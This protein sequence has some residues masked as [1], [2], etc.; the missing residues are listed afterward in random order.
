MCVHMYTQ[1]RTHVHELE[2]QIIQSF[3]AHLQEEGFI[4]LRANSEVLLPSGNPLVDVD[5][6]RDVSTIPKTH[7][8]H[9]NLTALL[10]LVG[11]S[12]QWY[13]ASERETLGYRWT[14]KTEYIR[15]FICA[16]ELCNI[17]GLFYPRGLC[18]KVI[19]QMQGVN[20]DKELSRKMDITCPKNIMYQFSIYDNS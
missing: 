14:F 3:K 19:K 1:K 18:F 12:E 2:N 4:K 9:T 16:F 17:Q 11:H 8:L 7:C 5:F 15:R 13:S 10:W 6:G 20:K